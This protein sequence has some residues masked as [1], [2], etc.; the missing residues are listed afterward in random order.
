VQF[1]PSAYRFSP[2]PGL[3]PLLLPPTTPLVTTVHEYGWWAAPGWVPDS[4]WRPLERARLWDR[5]TGR[6]VPASAAVVVS[7][8]QH[9]ARLQARTGKNPTEVPIASNVDDHQPGPGARDG[10]RRRL[11]L[12]PDTRLLAFF[13]FVHPVKGLRYVI[14]ALPSLR[15]TRPDLHLLVVGGFTSQALPEPEARAFRRDL[16]GLARQHG[17]DD[18]VTFTGHL[19]AAEVS[20]AL[21]AAD[22]AVL[23][24]TAGATTKSGAVLATLAHGLP[25]AVTLA[26]EPDPQLRDGDTVAVIPA[27]RDTAAVARTLER[28][29]DDAALRRR[30]ADGGRRLA[31]RHSWCRVATAHRNLYERVL[32][33]CN[34]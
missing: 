1:A 32:G 15:A 31:D 4:V 28:L 22:A 7:N 19:P 14:E 23:P 11:G 27:R 5:E 24:F 2:V 6:L 20:E 3:L 29:L 10:V 9:A 16:D 8:P 30:L 17:V 12:A 26:D 33:S 21:H 13:G 34:V 25:T 18:A